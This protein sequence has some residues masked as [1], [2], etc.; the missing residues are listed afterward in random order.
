M[1]WIVKFF[2]SGIGKKFLMSLTGIFLILF[3]I[4][5]LVGNLQLLKADDGEAFNTYAHFMTT[6]PLIKFVS[7]GLY[8]FIILHAVL[9][10]VIAFRNK[11]AKGIGYAVG[12]SRDVTWASKNM[13]L[14]GSLIL[15][16][17]L[18]HMGDFWFKMKFT[19]QLDMVNYEN[20]PH[21]VKDLYNRVSV[22]FSQPWI[23]VF[24]LAGMLVLS[25]HL[26]HGFQSAFQTLGIQHLKYTP[27]IHA[28]GKL[29]SILIPAAFAL[30][31]VYFYFFMK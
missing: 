16:F 21:A 23:V 29:Y 24:Y 28:I 7:Y 10:F 30:I 31:P 27:I 17:L 13:A 5:H 18:I 14:L 19:E 22:A 15:A 26:W 3:L 8:F 6:N 4:I 12:N 20:Y 25:F 9:G 2:D 11:V 1:N